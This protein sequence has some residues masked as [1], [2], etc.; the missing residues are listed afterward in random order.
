MFSSFFPAAASQHLAIPR[1]RS[2]RTTQD[3]RARFQ[4]NLDIISRPARDL[5]FA[6][7]E[8]HF[9]GEVVSNEMQSDRQVA[10]GGE[11]E[12]DKDSSL[13]AF[14]F[15]PLTSRP[16]NRPAATLRSLLHL[17]LAWFPPPPDKS[18]LHAAC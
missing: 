3:G 14:L 8:E 11:R 15:E 1:R 7:G 18:H 13:A 6:A 12:R 4:N 5:K 9:V 2:L 16:L 17:L 10:S